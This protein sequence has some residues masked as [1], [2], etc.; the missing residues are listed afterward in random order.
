MNSVE[1]DQYIRE[2]LKDDRGWNWGKWDESLRYRGVH[3]KHDHQLLELEAMYSQKIALLMRIFR[4]H[5]EEWNIL[6]KKQFTNLEDKIFR[7]TAKYRNVKS[8]IEGRRKGFLV[9]DPVGTTYYIDLDGGNDGSDGLGTG[10]AWL[11]YQQYSTTTVRTAGDLARIRANTDQLQGAADIAHD[12]DGTAALPIQ[13]I[14]CSSLSGNDPW[15]DASDVLPEIDFQNNNN[16]LQMSGD[17]FWRFERISITGSIDQYGAY[18]VTNY[19]QGV[20]FV[21]CELNGNRAGI[22]VAGASVTMDNCEASDNQDSGFMT[23]AGG[24]LYCFS[25]VAEGGAGLNQDAGFDAAQYG[26]M[27]CINCDSGLNQEHDAADFRTTQRAVLYMQNC[28]YGVAGVSYDRGS[29][30]NSQ[31]HLLSEDHDGAYGAQLREWYGGTVTKVDSIIRTGGSDSHAVMTPASVCSA[32]APVRLSGYPEDVTPPFR[33]WCPA[34]QAKTITFYCD[35]DLAW[36]PYPTADEFYFEASYYSGSAGTGQRSTVRSTQVFIDPNL[37]TFTISCTP[38][39]AG[40][41]YIDAFLE[42]YEASRY[43]RVDLRPDF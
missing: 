42:K 36:S 33:I 27:V 20:R 9:R 10:T 12:E 1:L 6:P 14:G 26:L 5:E 19:S 22:S 24:R 35:T 17:A 7:I 18:Q 30:G 38:T 25:C 34:N 39:Q 21:G 16:L 31:C 13:M 4:E 32:E 8:E 29:V 15:G 43:V 11:T 2:H 41:I 28:R 40:F 23:R 3:V 37:T